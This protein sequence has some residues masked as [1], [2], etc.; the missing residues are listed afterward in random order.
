M[1]IWFVPR[2]A[3]SRSV[4][5]RKDAGAHPEARVQGRPGQQEAEGRRAGA[6]ARAQRVILRMDRVVL[7]QICSL[8][9]HVLSARS[10]CKSLSLSLF[11]SL[12]FS[13]YT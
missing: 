7:P 11:T 6:A 5:G 1:S 9:L 2:D 8:L 10:D 3:A 12:A 13:P 4:E